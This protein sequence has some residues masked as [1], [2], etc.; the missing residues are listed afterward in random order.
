[1]LRELESGPYGDFAWGYNGNGTSRAPTA[2]LADTLELGTRSRLASPS[3]T[4][5][6]TA[7]WCD[8]AKRSATRSS[9]KTARSGG[10]PRCGPAVGAVWYGQAAITALPDG[11]QLPALDDD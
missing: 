6:R 5:W 1:V 7:S 3:T 8:C 10:W 2:I 4:A 9:P 11:L